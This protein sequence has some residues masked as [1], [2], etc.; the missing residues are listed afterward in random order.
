MLVIDQLTLTDYLSAS[1]H[2]QEVMLWSNKNRSMYLCSHIS[3]KC[4]KTNINGK[5]KNGKKKE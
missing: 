3:I 5:K 1:F 4:A 2:S